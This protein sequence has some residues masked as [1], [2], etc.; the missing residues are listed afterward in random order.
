MELRF[1]IGGNYG[2]ATECSETPHT[3]GTPGCDEVNGTDLVHPAVADR[4]QMRPVLSPDGPEVYLGDNQA[5]V[6]M[7]REVRHENRGSHREQEL[8]L[9]RE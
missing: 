1:H 7:T 8:Y 5:S 4:P 3:P 6:R 9:L 2:S